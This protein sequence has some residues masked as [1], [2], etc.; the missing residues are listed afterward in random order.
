MSNWIEYEVHT[1]TQQHRVYAVKAQSKDHAKRL[2][3]NAI[4]RD[5]DIGTKYEMIRI[6][7]SDEEVQDW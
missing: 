1:L 4:D 3:R 7:E 5:E 2:V 6:W